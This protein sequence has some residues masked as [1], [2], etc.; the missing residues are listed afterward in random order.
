MRTYHTGA[1]RKRIL[2]VL[3]DDGLLGTGD[4][5]YH[6]PASAASQKSRPAGKVLSVHE[7]GRVGLGLVRLEMAER[8]NWITGDRGR[9]TIEVDGKE[10]EIHA[11]KGEAYAAALEA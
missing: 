4:I 11:A 8:A 3:V 9:L 7:S 10:Q 1:T 6:P 2:P 5:T